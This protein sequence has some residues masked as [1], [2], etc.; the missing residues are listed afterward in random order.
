VSH[1]NNESSEVCGINKPGR[2]VKLNRQQAVN[3][4]KLICVS[5]R[6]VQLYMIGC[7]SVG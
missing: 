3:V 1:A 6:V 4:Y 7:K 5:H 2:R